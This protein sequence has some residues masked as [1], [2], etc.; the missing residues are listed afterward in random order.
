MIP[1][2]SLLV[3][4][5]ASMKWTLGRRA[6]RTERKYV[7]AAYEAEETAKKL[8][9]KPGNGK[10][11]PFATAKGQ[12][13]LGR[14]VEIR[15]ALEEKYLAHQGRHDTAGR[16]LAKVCRWK[17]RL[18]PYALGVIDVG[19]VL[20]A[21]HALGLPHSLTADTVREWAQAMAK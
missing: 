17:G 12:Y 15:D 18:V 13:E 3:A 4:A 1:L 11:D 20:A 10:A 19:L 8:Q 7:K 16:A 5:L 14:L 2:Y 9:V 21:L 6:V